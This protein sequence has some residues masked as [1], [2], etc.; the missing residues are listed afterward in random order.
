M[1]DSIPP[2]DEEATAGSAVEREIR[3][4]LT[5]TFEPA[6]YPVADPFTLLPLLP[7]GAETEFRAGAVV[8]PAIDL[9]LKYKEYQEFP[10]ESVELLVDDLIA[11][12][13]AE[14]DLPR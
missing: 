7:E 14:G 5:A 3:A 6:E 4:E 8:I 13:K 2:A 1:A 10:Y 11:A 12:M 9:G